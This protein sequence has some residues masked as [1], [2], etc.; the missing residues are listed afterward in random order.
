MAMGVVLDA[1]VCVFLWIF[2]KIHYFVR[3]VD[4]GRALCVRAPRAELFTSAA[5]L[6]R[7]L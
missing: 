7:L 5:V 6:V 1:T 3:T 2:L 4:E